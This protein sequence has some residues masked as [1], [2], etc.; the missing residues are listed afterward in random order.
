MDEYEKLEVDLEK[1][2]ETY[3]ERFRNLTYLEQQLEEFS[4]AEQ[5]RFEV[6]FNISYLY[7]SFVVIYVLSF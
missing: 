5:D 2:Y 4:R 3:L 1:Q 6:G 7:H